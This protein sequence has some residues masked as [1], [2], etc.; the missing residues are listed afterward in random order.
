[1][2]GRIF[3]VKSRSTCN[4]AFFSGLFFF[5]FGFSYPPE[6]KHIWKKIFTYISLVS[7][8]KNGCVRKRSGNEWQK[9]KVPCA[10]LKS[11]SLWPEPYK[12]CSVL[13]MFWHNYC[14]ENLWRS[15]WRLQQKFLWRIDNRKPSHK[16]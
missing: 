7:S 5:F 9:R 4:I 11:P 12:N 14:C 16:L 1:M 10:G 15:F 3:N 13:L 6:L 8:H 2:F